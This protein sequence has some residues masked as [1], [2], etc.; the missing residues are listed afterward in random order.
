MKKRLVVYLLCALLATVTLF[1][2]AAANLSPVELGLSY[3]AGSQNPDGS[4]GKQLDLQA[5]AFAITALKAAGV[6][7][8]RDAALLE[9]Q[10]LTGAYE[11]ALQS[12]GCRKT[13]AAQQLLS[14]QDA[15]GGWGDLYTSALTLYGLAGLGQPNQAAAAFLLNRQNDDGSWGQEGTSELTSIALTALV[16]AG[17]D[18]P[19]IM[20]GLDWLV[21]HQDPQGGWGQPTTTAWAI[22]ALTT[23]GGFGSAVAQAAQNLLVRRLPDNGWSLGKEPVSAVYSTAL[24]TWALAVVDTKEPAVSTGATYLQTHRGGSDGW[25]N[26]ELAIPTTLQVAEILTELGQAGALASATR[27]METVEPHTLSGMATRF[28]YLSRYGTLSPEEKSSITATL[29]A[30]E[31]P[32]GGWGSSLGYEGDPLTTSYV[33]RALWDAGCADPQL[34]G[35]ALAFLRTRQAA[36]GSFNM[37]PGEPGQ[38]YPTAHLALTLRRLQPLV[39]VGQ[40]VDPALNWLMT[41]RQGDGTWG[42][43]VLDTSMAFLA[44]AGK[45]TGAE[46]QQVEAL[47]E[48]KQ[49]ANGGWDRDDLTTGIALSALNQIRPNLVV[50]PEDVT[51]EPQPIYLHD[52]AT[53][54]V[55]VT[56]T[57]LK[58]ASDVRVKLYRGDAATGTLVGEQ[59]IAAIEAKADQTVSFQWQAESLGASPF[60]AVVDPENV[61]REEN[62]TDNVAAKNLVVEPK[63]DLA[64]TADDIVITPEAPAPIDLL[65]IKARVRN[66]GCLPAGPFDVTFYNGNPET[67]GTI[68]ATVAC[69]GVAGKQTAEVSTQVNLPEGDYQIFAKADS[70]H[71][72]AEDD[73]LN[74][75]GTEALTVQKRVDLA[76]GIRDIVFSNDKPWDGDTIRIFATVYNKREEAVD[77]VPVAFYS[78]D[79]ANGGTLLGRTTIARIEGN[80]RAQTYFDWDTDGISGRKIIYVVVDPDNTI[81]EVDKANNKALNLIF[82]TLRPDFVVESLIP[83]TMTEGT[84]GKVYF[85]IR[86]KGGVSASCL[87]DFYVSDGTQERKLGVT[88]TTPVIMPGEV[89]LQYYMT[90]DTVN[91]FGPQT[92]T[93][94][95]DPT[96]AVNE[97][98]ETNN[99]MSKSFTII[100]AP[101]VSIVPE[102]IAFSPAPVEDG[103]STTIAATVRNL[104]ASAFN[105][106]VVRLQE[107]VKGEWG[108]LSDKTIY[109]P[110]NQQALVSFNWDSSFKTGTHQFRIVLDPSGW[111]YERVETN[112]SAVKELTVLPASMPDLTV[113]PGTIS[114][115]P[116]PAARD[117]LVNLKAEIANLRGMA[118]QDVVV[119]FYDGNPQSGGIQIGPD[120]TVSVDGRGRS[121]VE[122]SWDTTGLSSYH[123]IYVW[124]DPLGA[125]PEY[126]KLN[127]ISSDTVCLR[128]NPMYQPQNL[129]ADVAYNDVTLT[130]DPVTQACVRGYLAYRNGTLINATVQPTRGTA[131][132]SSFYASYYYGSYPPERAIDGTGAYWQSQYST[133]EHW[134]EE[135]FIDF[136]FIEEIEIQWGSNI[137]QDYRVEVWDGDKYISLFKVTGNTAGKVTHRLGASGTFIKKYRIVISKVTSNV[138]MITEVKLKARALISSASLIDSDLPSGRHVYTVSSVYEGGESLPAVPVAVIVLPPEAPTGFT[139]LVQGPDVQLSWQAST[140]TDSQGY[141]LRRDGALLADLEPCTGT[142][143]AVGYHSVDYSPDKAV[144]GKEQTRWLYG[145]PTGQDAWWQLD[146]VR[147]RYVKS[148]TIK[149]DIL[150]YDYEVLAWVDEQWITLASVKEN[151]LTTIEHIFNQPCKTARIRIRITKVASSASIAEVNVLVQKLRADLNYRDNNLRTGTYDYTLTAENS[152]ACES[153]PV[154]IQ[155]TVNAPA[156]P[157]TPQVTVIGTDAN[158]TWTHQQEPGLIGYVVFRNGAIANRGQ[159]LEVAAVATAT[160]STAGNNANR[161]IDRNSATFW[162]ASM[163]GWLMLQFKYSQI[164]TSVK[165]SWKYPGAADYQVQYKSG[166]DWITVATVKGNVLAETMHDLPHPVWTDAVRVVFPTGEYQRYFEIS[167]VFVNTIAPTIETSMTDPGL[168]QGDYKYTVVA[169]DKA[170]NTST[171]SEAAQAKVGQLASPNNLQASASGNMVSLSWEMSSTENVAGYFVYRDQKWVNEVTNV[172]ANSTLSG[173][174]YPADLKNVVDD[175]NS[176]WTILYASW[177]EA[178]FPVPVD[179]NKIALQFGTGWAQDFNILIWKN[180]AWVTLREVRGNASRTYELLAPGGTFVRTEK[181]RIEFIKGTSYSGLADLKVYEV[182]LVKKESHLDAVI[183]NRW[184]EYQVRAA[185]TDG[186]LSGPSNPVLVKTNDQIP[187]AV[188][189]GFSAYREYNGR[190]TLQW[191]ANTEPDMA[192]Y[193]IYADGSDRPV[194]NALLPK[195]TVKSTCGFAMW[196]PEH[197]YRIVAVDVNGNQSA[198]A[199]TS[200]QFS[201]PA[202]PEN[203]KTTVDKKDIT[204]TWP[205]ASDPNLVG[206]LVYRDGALV[207]KTT[208]F[209]PS[210]SSC[211]SMYHNNGNYR[212]SSACDGLITTFWR[213]EENDEQPFI[214]F[215]YASIQLV[216]AIRVIWHSPSEIPQNYLIQAWINGAWSTIANGQQKELSYEVLPTYIATDR[217]RILCS[218]STNLI[219]LAEFSCWQAAL[220]YS[221]FLDANLLPGK[222]RYEVTAVNNAG[223]E[224]A[225]SLPVEAEIS[226]RDLTIKTGNLFYTPYQPSVFDDV[227]ISVKVSN[228]GTETTTEVPLALYLGDPAIGGAQIGS[229]IVGALEPGKETILQYVWDP[230]GC[231]GESRIYAVVDP[232]N[233]INEYDETNNST[234]RAITIQSSPSLQV[235]IS[236]VDSS[237]FPRIKLGVTA[238]DNLGEGVTGLGKENFSLGEN[239]QSQVITNLASTATGAQEKAKIDLVFVIDTSGSMDYE[240]YVMPGIIKDLTDSLAKIGID[241][242]Y[243]IYGLQGLSQ[244]GHMPGI[245]PL[246]LGIS[247]GRVIPLP[248]ENGYEYWAPATGWVAQNYPWRPGSFRIIIPISDESCFGG[249]P[250]TPSSLES[251]RET[252]QVC[253][254]NRVETYPFYGYF[255][256]PQVKDEMQLLALGTGGEAFFF[257]DGSQVVSYLL[258]VLSFKKTDYTIEYDSSNPSKD[259]TTRLVTLEA[260]YRLTKG[261]AQGQ[262]RAPQDQFSDL[263]AAAITTD[264]VVTENQELTVRATVRNEGGIRVE[265]VR[266]DFYFGDP[267]HGGILIDSQ[268]IPSLLPN[269]IV[270]VTSEWTSRPGTHRLYVVVDP[271]NAVTELNENNNTANVELHVPGEP[272]PDLSVSSS[273]VTFGRFSPSCGERVPITARVRN[274]GSACGSFQVA[275]YQGDPLAGGTLIATMSV[276]SLNYLGYKDVTCTWVA[277]RTP[278]L[279][280]I[281]VVVDPTNQIDERDEQNN[282]CKNDTTVYTRPIAGSIASDKPV[283]QPLEDVILNLTVENNRATAWTGSVRVLIRDVQGQT[284]KD[285]GMFNVTELAASANGVPGNWTQSTIW[286]AGRVA[287]GRYVACLQLLE[288]NDFFA[289]ST[290]EFEVSTNLALAGELATDKSVYAPADSAKIT[291]RLDNESINSTI[292]NMN[293]TVRVTDA[294]GQEVWS[295]SESVPVMPLNQGTVKTFTWPIGQSAG[296]SYTVTAEA[297][298][299]GKNLWSSSV[300]VQVNAKAVLTGSLAVSPNKTRADQTV[301][302][303]YTIENR[304]NLSLENVPLQILIVDPATR[305]VK[306]MFERSYSF[307]AGSMV[308]DGI[309]DFVPVPD[310]Q[311]MVVMQ[312]VIDGQAVPLSSGNLLVD[313]TPPV[314]AY[315]LTDKRLQRENALYGVVGSQLILAAHDNLIGVAE[316]DYDLGQGPVKYAGPITFTAEGVYTVKFHAIDRLGNTETEQTLQIVIDQTP[317][318]TR[319]VAPTEGREVWPDFTV[320][321][322]AS[323]NIGLEKAE[324]YVNGEKC[325]EFTTSPA[326]IALHRAP[327]EYTLQSRAVDQAGYETWSAPVKIRVINPDQVPPVTTATLVGDKWSDGSFKTDVVVTLTA[328]D[329]VGGTG[330]AAI[331]Y[332]LDNDASYTT[333]SGPF[334]VT[335][336]GLH[337]LSFYAVDNNNNSETPQ[338]LPFI[339]VKPWSGEGLVCQQLVAGGNVNATWIFSNGSVSINGN[340]DFGYLGTVQPSITQVGSVTIDQLELNAPYRCLPVPDWAALQNATTLRTES[341][342]TN[343][344]SLANARF[345]HDLSLSGRVQ[346]TG[347]L[348][349]QGNLTISGDAVL[350]DAGIFCTGTITVS[351]KA[352]IRG[353]IYAGAGLR[354]SGTPDIAITGGLVVNGLADFSGDLTTVTGVVDSFTIWLRKTDYD[355]GTVTCE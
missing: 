57:G 107:N 99:T 331:Y 292:E 258:R 348:V 273:E 246:Y 327:G 205:Y 291:I 2:N 338:S 183:E 184:Y 108:T 241:L 155:A 268:T 220:T 299:V 185:A 45:L 75:T 90:L 325:A 103:D 347:L 266:V 350:E 66:L 271:A 213:P 262:Y 339:L 190:V 352:S 138:A 294:N 301:G 70:N 85:V 84:P 111:V 44:L 259:G 305:E 23:R 153:N 244:Y 178:S 232:Q 208:E 289:E 73:E 146:F 135:E 330:V 179:V 336:E 343:A 47:L 200:F 195:S 160:S 121:L 341:S 156:T 116:A 227:T 311:Y 217:V 337:N 118:A 86:N 233:I 140:T 154:V 93:I 114:V 202:V 240:W 243:K 333:Y 123:E 174:A 166:N 80:N 109:V 81:I 68:I 314:T 253:K 94:N 281:Y 269:Q 97:S 141:Y 175:S 206:F 180:S 186:T 6:N 54:H 204:V 61:V 32:G 77:N 22:L 21:Q 137:A 159:T 242:N 332:K 322:E 142:A 306:K 115:N 250:Q 296:G 30:V 317:P 34:Y 193:Y 199:E 216:S 342:F 39:P 236:Q 278:G 157:G 245:E 191:N 102:D 167:E 1:S 49:A 150:A 143:S 18:G 41:Q 119:R 46:A 51:F 136:Q 91:L 270:D 4:W 50:T 117:S 89:S 36:D 288:N 298:A 279:Q 173:S 78:D 129:K 149:W 113:A 248:G 328:V 194:N 131:K 267:Q 334:T 55:K 152:L 226:A 106:L 31:N 96:N 203:V 295:D 169:Y 318:A 239:G 181:I 172:A 321:V 3:L 304:G 14:M 35:R 88:V 285:L 234:S 280:S 120:Q 25:Y 283:Y 310:G 62:E 312:A 225:R 11:L 212:A 139:A 188:P 344:V 56:N 349:V 219:G 13:G 215:Q 319:I 110:G 5:T 147:E 43:G 211:S 63:V 265:N 64:L 42:R 197:H 27:W 335:R 303:T 313:S 101:D 277:P 60:T 192:G 148:L 168:S 251:I 222:Y 17:Q 65:T 351:G 218:K 40:V 261:S 189:T 230:T 145:I 127:N 52:Q 302:F 247:G 29:Y 196:T 276:P 286:N 272:K 83:E 237:N 201:P 249:D 170:G 95:L 263:V 100:P 290:S 224:S 171:P 315:T 28:S 67:G 354:I 210:S 19:A 58:S 38:I 74:N 72:I 257:E 282:T 15:D 187:P 284:V 10:T 122:V 9:R 79:P 252:V 207:N 124:V 134:F 345:E 340:V 87:V 254:A 98:N 161:V 274:T 309:C 214:E 346:V 8:D 198:P 20:K 326:D 76:I 238:T 130:W 59:T 293:L 320:T 164:I 308:A 209:Y 297:T 275:F 126:N 24:A 26:K 182:R 48:S 151:K 125:L 16:K 355:G 71:A 104:T 12:L 133:G 92:V 287:P 144:D 329:N 176:C 231:A 69:P 300:A 112:N 229:L 223:L 235:S 316:I 228:V 307:T 221:P 264:P 128:T 82:I 162:G 158:L 37:M 7:C 163:P 260:S 33:L 255:L 353:T 256:N 323:D 177:I 324:L 132:A 53:I 165:I 105:N